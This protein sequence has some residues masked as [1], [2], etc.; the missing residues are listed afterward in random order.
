MRMS[1]GLAEAGVEVK[2]VFLLSPGLKR[3]FLFAT[4]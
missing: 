3:G 4:A 1:A 2:E